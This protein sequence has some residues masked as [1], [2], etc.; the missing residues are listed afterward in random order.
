MPTSLPPNANL[1]QL[2]HQAK[3]LLKAHKRG[4]PACCEVLRQLR[5]FADSSDA[6]ILS[7]AVKLDDAQ[8]ALAMSYAFES[9]AKLKGHVEAAAGEKLSLAVVH[10]RVTSEATGEPIEGVE[11][12]LALRDPSCGMVGNGQT[13]TDADGHY[14]CSIQWRR[15]QRAELLY[16]CCHAHHARETCTAVEPGRS[17]HRRLRMSDGQRYEIDISLKEGY[18]LELTVENERGEPVRDAQ[19]I[20]P[21]EGVRGVERLVGRVMDEGRWSKWPRTDAGGLCRAEGLHAHLAPGHQCAAEIRH[22][23]YRRQVLADA[24]VLPRERHVARATIQL[25]EGP[26]LSGQVICAETGRPVEGARIWAT[27]SGSAARTLMPLEAFGAWAT[28]GPDGCFE[29]CGLPACP[30]DLS[31]SHGGWLQARSKLLDVTSNEPLVVQLER[32][33]VISGEVIDRHGGPAAEARVLACWSGAPLELSLNGMRADDLGRFEIGGLPA[34]GPVCVTA[35]SDEGLCG[36][37]EIGPD[38]RRVTF[39][40]RDLVEVEVVVVDDAGQPVPERVLSKTYIEW[41]HEWVALGEIRVSDAD[42]V[43]PVRLPANG[44]I[45]FDLSA[46]EDTPGRPFHNIESVMMRQ[47]RP[48]RPMTFTASWP[49][50]LT[51]TCL[52]AQTGKP[53]PDVLVGLKEPAYPC[54]EATDDQGQV[55][56]DNLPPHKISLQAF[57]PHYEAVYQKTVTLPMDEGLVIHLTPKA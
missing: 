57:A 41:M 5:Q 1:T 26:H 42:G 4:D 47:G 14:Q 34:Q 52:D 7:A 44:R 49:C 18:A 27:P 30:H 11:V 3:D 10:G 39:D 6:D 28:S 17:P 54:Q 13:R 43:F 19:I 25:A 55:V 22:S 20:I 8:F 33:C 15:G 29:T 23:D 50:K 45:Q 16:E 56:F 9:W 51:V 21:P 37:V 12:R 2:K 24:A 46:Y 31:V 40:A 38:D 32:G 48:G 53:I 36:V 35:N